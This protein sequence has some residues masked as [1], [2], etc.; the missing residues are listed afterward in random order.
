MLSN[1][2]RIVALLTGCVLVVGGAFAAVAAGDRPSANDLARESA[3]ASIFDNHTNETSKQ[4]VQD[5][6]AAL[7]AIGD[8]HPGSPVP[9]PS[10]EPQSTQPW[11]TGVLD[12]GEEFPLSMGYAF[13]DATWQGDI[14]GSHVRVYAGTYSNDSK[15]GVIL[16]EYI[17]PDTW[18]HTFKGPFETSGTG[19]LTVTSADGDTLTLSTEAAGKVVFDVSNLAFT[20]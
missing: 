2:N 14:Q 12:G 20:G 13:N 7:N 1:R 9:P 16:V 15:T 19:S 3:V 8:E 5:E 18:G 17:D 11:D 6:D 4:E 10:G